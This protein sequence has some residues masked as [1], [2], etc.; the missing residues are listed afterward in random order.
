MNAI[1]PGASRRR[2]RRTRKFSGQSALE[3]F[4]CC[5]FLERVLILQNSRPI[6]GWLYGFII[7]ISAAP[8]NN[9]C[10]RGLVKFFPPIAYNLFC[11][12]TCPPLPGCCLTSS[13]R[14]GYAFPHIFLRHIFIEFCLLNLLQASTHKTDRWMGTRA[15]NWAA[16]VSEI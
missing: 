15:E 1:G 12:R 3:S 10:I 13:S 5:T 11:P 8:I 9:P 2:P 4:A 16:R 14:I 7:P 6:R